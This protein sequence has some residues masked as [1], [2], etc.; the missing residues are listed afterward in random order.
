MEEE[1]K[2]G[3]VEVWLR[4]HRLQFN[5]ATRHPFIL[6]IRDGTIHIPSFK[7]WLVH[8]LVSVFVLFCFILISKFCLPFF[9]INCLQL[10]RNSLLWGSQFTFLIN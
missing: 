6:S 2:V 1:K 8:S 3:I 9:A 5:A 10:S 4:K 7:T